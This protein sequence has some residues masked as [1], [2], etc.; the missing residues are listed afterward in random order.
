MRKKI[1]TKY[2]LRMET[3]KNS[4][5]P[6]AQSIWRPCTSTSSLIKN[7]WIA[8]PSYEIKIYRKTHFKL[9]RPPIMCICFKL[10]QIT[11]T[12]FTNFTNLK[13]KIHHIYNE[14][15]ADLKAIHHNN[16]WKNKSDIIYLTAGIFTKL[17]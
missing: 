11:S 1:K 15:T 14:S 7:L 4:D 3:Q 6:A 12:M 2:V 9:Y 16:I 17:L 10:G 5:I 8:F 13:R